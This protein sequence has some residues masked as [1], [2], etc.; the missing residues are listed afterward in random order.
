[1]SSSSHPQRNGVLEKYHGW[2]S[3]AFGIVVAVV[4]V[5]GLYLNAGGGHH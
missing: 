4:F 5:G 1:M 2:V 3:W